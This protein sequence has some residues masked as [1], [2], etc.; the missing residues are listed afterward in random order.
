MNARVYPFEN[1][2]IFQWNGKSWPCALGRSGVVPS[3]QKHEGDGATPAGL[4]PLRYFFYRPDRLLP[5]RSALPGRAL[6]PDYGWCDTPQDPCYNRLVTLPCPMHAEELWRKDHVYD[7][8]VVL[9]YNDHPVH[10]FLG[11]AI[12]LHSARDGYP[13]TAG[14]IALSRQ[15]LISFLEQAGP[16]DHLD[17]QLK[18]QG[19]EGR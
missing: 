5:P 17:I 1:K 11:S 12:F 8:I 2:G 18:K 4:L 10:P 3:D 19:E 15:H 7:I 13:P 14:C 6:R 9:G 16:E